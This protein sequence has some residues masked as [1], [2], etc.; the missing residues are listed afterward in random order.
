MSPTAP[1]SR[2]PSGSTTRSAIGGGG[3]AV[4]NGL[5]RGDFKRVDAHIG[6]GL[7]CQNTTAEL[8]V[9]DGQVVDGFIRMEDGRKFTFTN[10]KR[11][12]VAFEG[13]ITAEGAMN[14]KLRM[15]DNFKTNFLNVHY[16]G[17]IRGDMVEGEWRDDFGHCRGPFRLERKR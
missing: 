10:Q 6:S 4:F 5:W 1:V 9:V 17:L 11:G 7:R 2:D 15:Y 16:A 8:V 12:S 14:V 13:A 3:A